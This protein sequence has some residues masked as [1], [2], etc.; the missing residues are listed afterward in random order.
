LP[1]RSELPLISLW[2]IPEAELLLWEPVELAP[3][4]DDGVALWLLELAPVEDDG[5]AVWSLELLE[6]GDVLWELLELEG[7]VLCE[8][9]ELEA[10]GV[11]LEE[12]AFW[13]DCGRVDELELLLLGVV[14]LLGELELL[15]PVWDELVAAGLV[16]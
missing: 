3:V 11:E 14:E 7:D 9:L 2:G 8:L 13:S 1:C 6:E 4:E 12:G 15:L 10:E 5:F 16:D